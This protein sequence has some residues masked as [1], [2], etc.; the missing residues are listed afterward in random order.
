MS[1]TSASDHH[2]QNSI[3][4]KRVSGKTPV[5][6]LDFSTWKFLCCLIS[7]SVW[8][9]R[10]FWQPY[11]WIDASQI[12]VGPTCFIWKT[13]QNCGVWLDWTWS[14]NRF[15][16]MTM[17]DLHFSSTRLILQHSKQQFASKLATIH[18]HTKHTKSNTLWSNS[19]GEQFSQLDGSFGK[20]NRF[21]VSCQIHFVRSPVTYNF[22]NW[23]APIFNP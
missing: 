23:T 20:A 17:W 16:N 19:K 4:Q 5:L 2:R 6:I 18:W 15:V 21:D 14:T 11:W 3:A 10:M 9:W 7:S 8:S 12:C 1:P 13:T 22:V